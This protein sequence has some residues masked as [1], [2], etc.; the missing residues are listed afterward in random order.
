MFSVTDFSFVS[1]EVGIPFATSEDALTIYNCTAALRYGSVCVCVCVLVC[2]CVCVCVCVG[3]CVCVC[4][5]VLSC[6]Y[7]LS[8]VWSVWTQRMPVAGVC[9]EAPVVP[10][11]TPVLS[12]LV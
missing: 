6:W 2:V 8:V 4:V 3:V 5:C 11:L 10:P 9:M 7:T 12:L 1:V